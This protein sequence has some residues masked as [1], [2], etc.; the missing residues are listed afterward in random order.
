MLFN[1]VVLRN[2]G[3]NDVC[4][5]S[6]LVLAFLLQFT[7][8]LLVFLL[9]I[10]NAE[11]IVTLCLSLGGKGVLTLVKL[12]FASNLELSILALK[13]LLLSDLLAAGLALTLFEGTLGTES[14]NL[15]LSVGSLLLHLTETGNFLLLLFLDAALLK[16]LGDFMLNFFLIVT[17]N[18]LLLVK[19]LLSKFGLL[20][21]GNCVGSLNFS[22]Q[23]HVAG[24]FIIGSLNL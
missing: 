15:R 10:N 24:T 17:D 4:V 14:I 2:L 23:A 18:L 1:S 9:A 20:G 6:K 13:T 21:E 8:L 16:S 12:S 19:L 22:D 11:E 3:A 5:V 7:F